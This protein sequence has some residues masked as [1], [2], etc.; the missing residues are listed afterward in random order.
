MAKPANHSDT[1][2]QLLRAAERRP[3]TLPAGQ[4]EL[5]LAFLTGHED[6][7]MGWSSTNR[8]MTTTRLLRLLEAYG[9]SE[10]QAAIAEAL[11]RGVPHPNAVRLSLE[12]AR[13][14]AWIRR[15]LE[16]DGVETGGGWLRVES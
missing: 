6:W 13:R 11:H 12:R 16:F 2:Q 9:A 15:K 14:L 10:L 5:L 3:G 7:K 1:R 4:A 8:P